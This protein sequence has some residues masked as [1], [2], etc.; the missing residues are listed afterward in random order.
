M[1]TFKDTIQSAINN[2]VLLDGCGSADRIKWNGLNID[3]CGMS[4]E[5][6]MKPICPCNCNGGGTDTGN[7]KT[8]LTL[9]LSYESNA[10]GKYYPIVSSNNKTVGGDVQI[11]LEINGETLN[12]ILPKGSTSIKSNTGF[13]EMLSA[14]KFIVSNENE[15]KEMYSKI[16][17]VNYIPKGSS[18]TAYTSVINQKTFD[19]I[20]NISN[21]D[22]EITST[23]TFTVEDET[24][25]KV[26]IPKWSVDEPESDDE[27]N[28]W[29]FE[30][31]YA[32]LLYIPKEI[33]IKDITETDIST[34]EYFKQI[35]EKQISNIDYIIYGKVISESEKNQD[36]PIVNI[37]NSIELRGYASESEPYNFSYKLIKK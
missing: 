6:Y 33:E 26:Y 5:E 19:T 9:T 1:S 15:L 28:Q 35:G 18:N 12:L 34:L 31:A 25:L 8:I 7:T 2:G 37:N 30:N 22:F 23:N 13:D 29:L 16:N 20:S 32:L 36:E 27:Y 24:D 14:T 4:V 3:L 10:D 17:V 11:E 21:F